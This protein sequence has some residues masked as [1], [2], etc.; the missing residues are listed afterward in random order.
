MKDTLERTREPHLNLKGYLRN[1]YIHPV[2]KNEEDDEYEENDDTNRKLESGVVPT[3]R[4]ARRNTPAPS[5]HSSVGSSS[6]RLGAVPG[7]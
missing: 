3:K 1:A 4:Q 7:S 6:S 5:K 2:F